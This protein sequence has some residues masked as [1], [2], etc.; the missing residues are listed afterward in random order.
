MFRTLLFLLC[1]NLGSAYGHLYEVSICSIFKDEA[2]F[3]KEWIEFH[4]IQ[5]VEHFYLYNNF[6]SDNFEEVLKPYIASNEVTLIDWPYSYGYRE[7]DRWHEIQFNAYMDCI[8][9]YGEDTLWLAVLDLDE[10]LFCP[11]GQLLNDFLIHFESFG[12]LCVNWLVFGT[13]GVEEIPEGQTMIETLTS[14]ADKKNRWNRQGKSIV[15]P[16]YVAGAENVHTFRFTEGRF[17]IETN[18]Q[19]VNDARRLTGHSY[20]LIQINHYWTRTESWFRDKKIASRCYRRLKNNKDLLQE[21][22]DLYNQSKNH[23]ILRFVPQLRKNMGYDPKI[24]V[25][26]SFKDFIQ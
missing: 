25:K 1:L 11:K 5:G 17:C 2:P 21:R 22:A 8:N 15:Q 4:K 6:S 14:C 12:G 19:I 18:G 24:P 16:K 23:A 26:R 3:I 20:P 13:S 7:I 9:R 10:F